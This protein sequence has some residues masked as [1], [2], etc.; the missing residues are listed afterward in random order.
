M[1]SFCFEDLADSTGAFPE[2]TGCFHALYSRARG[3]G[4]QDW[5]R[6]YQLGEMINSSP[7]ITSGS[8]NG[9]L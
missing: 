3:T 9:D 1:L 8:S 7:K 6:S 2:P 5:G 4:P